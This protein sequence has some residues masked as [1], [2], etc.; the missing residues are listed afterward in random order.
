[1]PVHI[2]MYKG[3]SEP[4]AIAILL[5][6]SIVF[7]LS[8]VAYMQSDYSIRQNKLA[9]VRVIEY[10]KVNTIMRMIGSQGNAY[11]L[12]FKR[13]D[14]G[15]KIY[16]FLYNGTRY[17]NCT[18]I[19]KDIV[20]GRVYEVNRH[21]INDILALSKG[22]PYSFRYY[23]R[24]SGY[25]DTG[26]IQI[27]AVEI[28]RNAISVLSLSQDITPTLTGPRSTKVESNNRRWRMYGTIEFTVK[29]LGNPNRPDHLKVNGTGYQLRVGDIIRVDIDTSLGK[30]D[31]TPQ[32]L[33]TGELGGWILSFNV[34]AKEIRI[35][36]A[37]LAK[38]VRVEIVPEVAIDINSLTSSLN[39]EVYPDPPGFIRV[40]YGDQS[41]VDYWNNSDYIRIIGW[42]VNSSIQM[43]LQLEKTNLYAQGIATA[44][45][46]GPMPSGNGIDRLSIFIVTYVNNIPYLVDVYDYKFR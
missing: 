2:K 22:E 32:Q 16:F 23:A 3:L 12:L 45:Y 37:L 11:A 30:I 24:A 39:I 14:S 6:V 7:V 36:N 9:L 46:I 29:Y 44:V 21:N 41:L 40:R 17:I 25:S 27:C 31:I 4:L 43:V 5:G 20:N 19:I 18:S 34:S 28:D 38:N 15:N 8:F 42:K 33:P 26:D 10:E 35:N 13:L 1:M